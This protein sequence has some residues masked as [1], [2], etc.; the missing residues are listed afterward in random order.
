M[1]TRSDIVEQARTYIDARWQHQG[2]LPD[3]MDCVGLV[4]LVGTALGMEH[5]DITGYRR[6]PEGVS[7][8]RHLLSA[9]FTRK[10]VGDR[11]PGDLM[12]FRDTSQPCHVAILGERGG[13]ETIIHA[14]AGKKKV[15]E[16]PYDHEWPTKLV[17][18]YNFPG[19]A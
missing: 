3:R 7:L 14:S 10:P 12:A 1:R 17:A 15:L 6:T 5:Y 16:E 8:L 18:C 19:V 11:Q 13:E 2:R 4:V 9:G